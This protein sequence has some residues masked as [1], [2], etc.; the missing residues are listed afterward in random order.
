MTKQELIDAIT[1]NNK[2]GLS[3]KAATEMVDEV[4]KTIRNV[5]KK[6][7][8]FSYP[9]FGTWVIRHRKARN[10]INPQT[11]APIKIKASKTVGFRPA[12][13]FKSKL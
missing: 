12:K 1:K 13:E 4:F 7:A 9:G 8:R 3:K 10:G 6:E 11:K 5:V 2:W